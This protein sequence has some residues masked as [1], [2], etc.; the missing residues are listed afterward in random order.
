MSKSFII[1]AAL[2]LAS[3]QRTSS[4]SHE[5]L[6]RLTAAHLEARAFK[7]AIAKTFVNFYAA[8]FEGPSN[9]QDNLRAMSNEERE[10][11]FKSTPMP[12]TTEDELVA[13]CQAS[14]HR[15]LNSIVAGQ[16]DA[17]TSQLEGDL[18]SLVRSMLQ[19]DLKADKSSLIG[20][21][22]KVLKEASEAVEMRL[23]GINQPPLLH[24]ASGQDYDAIRH[25]IITRL[26]RIN[27]QTQLEK[28]VLIM[29]VYGDSHNPTTSEHQDMLAKAFDSGIIPAIEEDAGE[30]SDEF[31]HDFIAPT[32]VKMLSKKFNSD[33]WVNWSWFNNR[34]ALLITKFGHEQQ[35]IIFK[36]VLSTS[37]TNPGQTI[38]TTE[39]G[40]RFRR[41][42][43]NRFETRREELPFKERWVLGFDY[44]A[45]RPEAFDTWIF[46]WDQIDGALKAAGN[47]NN[48]LWFIKLFR[49]YNDNP[50][51][52]PEQVR[53]IG[54][55]Y[56]ALYDI[57]LTQ[58]AFAEHVNYSGKDW[59]NHI[60]SNY[61]GAAKNGAG[62][63]FIPVVVILSAMLYD[64]NLPYY[65]RQ[66]NVHDPEEVYLKAISANDDFLLDYKRFK[67]KGEFPKTSFGTVQNVIIPDIG[68]LT[69][70]ER[71]VLSNPESLKILKDSLANGKKLI[72]MTDLNP[73]FDSDDEVLV[74]I[75]EREISAPK[76]SW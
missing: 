69:E 72:K 6:Q 37:L 39:Y 49:Y 61:Y 56:D 29:S 57:L 35:K 45:C 67:G 36:R 41:Y 3:F 1:F 38:E 25:T 48:Y 9:I 46:T 5:E 7:V 26:R 31:Y 66:Y 44:L 34:V 18:L 75:L 33:F 47:P 73:E 23:A 14:A 15:N 52:D 54:E 68:E 51:D 24:G 62:A 55:I 8:S 50:Q 12:V 16:F 58:R 4:I 64:K 13:S 21:L 42:I 28:G 27:I 22:D 53:K 70:D 60:G 76:G 20:T 10:A 11:H 19:K 2:I 63:K 30:E 17:F 40:Q 59:A 71:L 65:S 32:I 43:I 74:Y